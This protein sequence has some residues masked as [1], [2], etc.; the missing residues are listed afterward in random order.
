MTSFFL[1]LITQPLKMGSTL[2]GKNLVMREQI[3]SFKSLTPSKRG[4]N[5][6]CSIASPE[7]LPIHLKSLSMQS[8]FSLGF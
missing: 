8:G 4:Q 3:L 1:P 7:G 6:N 2:K 5:K